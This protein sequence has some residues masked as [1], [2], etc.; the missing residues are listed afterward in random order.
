MTR[1]FIPYGMT[2]Y[3]A[4]NILDAS[5]PADVAAELESRSCEELGGTSRRFVG[6]TSLLA[7]LVER[8]GRRLAESGQYGRP[9]A[10]WRL[11]NAGL[12]LFLSLEIS[13]L[14]K[15]YA[16][17]SENLKVRGVR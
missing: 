8:T 15:I 17:A 1:E 10:T 7:E 11:Y 13:E 6:T 12:S 5:D 4:M 2:L 14:Q 9:I 16:R 3:V